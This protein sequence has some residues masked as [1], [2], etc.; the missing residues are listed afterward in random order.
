MKRFETGGTP[1]VAI[2]D[3]KGDLRFSHFGRFDPAPVERFI[4]RILEDEAEEA[5]NIRS[6]PRSKVQS[7][8]RRANQRRAD[9]RKEAPP[10]RPEH[11]DDPEEEP[12]PPMDTGSPDADSAD[13][14]ADEVEPAPNE[15]DRSLTG[16][17]RL[18]FEE[19]SKTCGEP[20]RPVDVITQ[21]TVFPDRIEAN[22]SRAVLGLRR[23]TL[24]FDEGSGQFDADVQQQARDR[25][26][27]TVDLDLQVRGRF[28][29]IAE[30]PE[31]EYD[32]RYE[33][34]SEDGSLDCI[35]EGRGGGP[36]FRGR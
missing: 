26:G 6:E 23:L 7:P 20:S 21:V 17:Y 16:S 8:S 11:V 36:R 19:L 29:N 12:P 10:L 31:V 35:I 30:P 34:L 28:V 33:K 14:E 18:R 4:T 15:P 1:H 27:V 3:G 13:D 2:V 5:R 25:G 24:R 32:Y 9:R 22:F